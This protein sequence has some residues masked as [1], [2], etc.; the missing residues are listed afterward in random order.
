ML[1]DFKFSYNSLKFYLWFQRK[2]IFKCIIKSKNDWLLKKYSKYS[3][4]NF[5]MVGVQKSVIILC[6][7]TMR[8]KFHRI[9]SRSLI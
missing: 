4:E 8:I 5:N 6:T 3:L 9:F 7:K 1:F 2:V